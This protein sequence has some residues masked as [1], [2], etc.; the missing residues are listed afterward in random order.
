MAGFQVV[1]RGEHHR[2]G[3]DVLDLRSV[4]TTGDADTDVQL[5][6]LVK[7]D[8][9]EGLVDLDGENRQHLCSSRMRPS[10]MHSSIVLL[11]VM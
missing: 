10:F 4:A 3:G 2:G 5:G 7:A 9:E 8:D 1:A 11:F 6:E